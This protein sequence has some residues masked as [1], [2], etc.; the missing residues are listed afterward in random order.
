MNDGNL[1]SKR[2]AAECV[3]YTLF[4]GRFGVKIQLGA[5]RQRTQQQCYS[6]KNELIK[7]LHNSEFTLLNNLPEDIIGFAIA[8][9]QQLSA[10]DSFDDR[11][12]NRRMAECGLRCRL[13]THGQHTIGGQSMIGIYVLPVGVRQ[14]DCHITCLT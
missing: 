8:I 12:G 7:V 6:K 14:G 2:H 9:K 13:N 11:R 3:L 5:H 4:D 1:F 10:N